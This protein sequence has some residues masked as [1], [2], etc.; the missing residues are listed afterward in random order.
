[1]VNVI[2]LMMPSLGIGLCVKRKG[3]DDLIEVE[4]ENRQA[5]EVV[6][7]DISGSQ[8]K[9]PEAVNLLQENKKLRLK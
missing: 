3:Q 6:P 1:M 8:L 5:V 7:L 2:Q 4:K 9:D